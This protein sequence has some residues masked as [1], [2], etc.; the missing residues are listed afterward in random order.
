M[1]EIENNEL[2]LKTAKKRVA[3][4][5]HITF[6]ILIN[7]LL[8]VVYFIPIEKKTLLYILLFVSLTWTIVIICHYFIAMKWNKKMLEKE[9]ANL[10]KN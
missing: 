9:I 7:L 1:N 6:Y 8:W 4:K 5:K 3:F 2:I 10:I